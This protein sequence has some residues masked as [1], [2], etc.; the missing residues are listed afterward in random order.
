MLLTL[1]IC[2]AWARYLPNISL[3]GIPLN[4][5]PFTIKEHVLI[6]I[7]A[8]VGTSN[9]YAVSSPNSAIMSGLFCSVRALTIS[10]RPRLLPLRK[11]FTISIPHLPV[12][13]RASVHSYGLYKSTFNNHNT[14]QWLLVM[15]TQ[16]IGLSVG[17]IYKRF[18][19]TPPSMIWPENLLSA[20]LFNTLHGQETWGTQVRGGISRLRFFYYVFI[21]YIFYSQFFLPWKVPFMLRFSLLLFLDF[22]PSYLFT[23]LSVFSWV[24][25][26]APNN[27]KVNQLFGVNH[28]LGMGILTFD[29]GQITFAGSP[30]PTPWWV[31][32]NMG[33]TFAF[34]YWFLIPILYVRLPCSVPFAFLVYL[35]IG[36]CSTPTFGTALTFP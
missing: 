6:T 28:G 15:S 14:D 11:S 26:I 33:V 2:K 17:G 30:F 34:F 21:G 22:L 35:S 20:V 24:C 8:G 19:V 12:S 1:P 16:L 25:W 7:M 23:A 27:V 36:F 31:A 13:F 3:F 10:F 9:G 4:P 29:W 18:V 32:A 5:G